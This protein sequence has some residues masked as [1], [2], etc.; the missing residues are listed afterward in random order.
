MSISEMPSLR[1]LL[2]GFSFD[3]VATE[4]QTSVLDLP[5]AALLHRDPQAEQSR[6]NTRGFRV[7]ALRSWW[8]LDEPQELV[9]RIVLHRMG[10]PTAAALGVADSWSEVHAGNARIHR[11]DATTV[12][13]V[14]ED[15]AEGT[16]FWT[17]LAFGRVDEIVVTAVGCASN[18]DDAT[19]SC[20]ALVD[21]Q[22]ARLK[23]P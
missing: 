22:M 23:A 17:A 13:L 9:A 20:S 5:D 10:D 16:T 14:S 11:R 15:D 7:G 8:T 1:S 18:A 12:A 2:V 21:A 4:T 3:P 19:R 6:L